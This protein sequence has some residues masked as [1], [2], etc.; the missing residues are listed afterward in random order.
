MQYVF[1]WASGAPNSRAAPGSPHSSCDTVCFTAHL[2]T[3]WKCTVS[4]VD[5]PICTRRTTTHQFIWQQ[6]HTCGI[7][8][9]S[10]MRRGCT[11]PRDSVFSSGTLAPILGEWSFQEQCGSSLTASAPVSDVSVPACTNGVCPPLLHVSVA[12]NKPS[13]MLS[14]NVQS[15]DL[16]MDCTAWRFSM[17]RQAP[18]GTNGV[19]YGIVSHP[20]RGYLFLRVPTPD[21]KNF[22]ISLIPSTFVYELK[23]IYHFLI[24]QRDSTAHSKTAVTR[25]SF[26]YRRLIVK[27][28]SLNFSTRRPHKIVHLR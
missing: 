24:R 4:Q 18:A 13:T 14:S 26:C 12:Q 16:H 2:S 28:T 1:L 8:G 17:M 7:L 23:K 3:E 21:D 20:R 22:K 6:Q 25:T 11:T 5:T 15:I 19:C 27:K 9:R 10:R